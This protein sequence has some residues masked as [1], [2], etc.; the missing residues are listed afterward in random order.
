M[1]VLLF[2][3]ALVPH[4]TWYEIYER[5]EK[6]FLAKNYRAC[7]VDMNTAL[8][9]KPDP[10]RNQ[11]TRAVQKIDYKPF[12]YKAL[13]YQQLDNLPK[14]YE[15]AQHAFA[16]EVVQHAPLLQAK[17]AVILEHYRQWVSTFHHRYAKERALISQRAVILELLADGKLEEAQERL[18]QVLP[19]KDFDDLT[20]Q[21]Q[22]Q[23]S[24]NTQ[25]MQVRQ[26]LLNR[27]TSWIQKKE[28]TKAKTLFEAVGSSL[29]EENQLQI[30]LELVSLSKLEKA[31]PL[32][33][34]NRQATR[35]IEHFKTEI[36]LLESQKQNLTARVIEIEAQNQELQNRL[37]EEE[38]AQPSFE[39]SLTLLVRSVRALKVSLDARAILPFPIR[40]WQLDINGE[41]VFSGEMEPPEKHLFEWSQELVLKEFGHQSLQLRVRDNA[42]HHHQTHTTLFVKK[43][44]HHNP[45]LHQL[46]L[47]LIVLSV[48]LRLR[49]RK[50]QRKNARLLHFN[51]YIA[52]APIRK[53]EMFFGRDELL[54][55]I[56]SLVHKNSFMIHGPRRIGK[57]S[58]LLRL[59]KNLETLNS[60]QY[61][62]YPVLSDLQGIREADLFHH[63]MM[64]IL[65]QAEHWKIELP[66]LAFSDHSANYHTRYFSRDLRQLIETLRAA[67]DRHVILVLLIDEVDVL[68]E[69]HAKTNQKLRSIFMKDYAEHLTGVMAGIHLKKEWESSGSPWYNFFEEIPIEPLDELAARK[70]ITTPV[71]GVFRFHKNA[72]PLILKECKGHPYIIQKVC[73]SLIETKLKQNQ[74]HI[75]VKDVSTTLRQLENELRSQ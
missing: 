62:F 50:Q 23:K 56:Q 53:L 21:L 71:A 66:K 54:H 49:M 70:L 40:S 72:I 38:Q 2:F 28:Y 58:L 47:L 51:P 10:K 35:E 75:S 8:R 74:F 6:H 32:G 63:L 45:L 24:N 67:N 59:E 16:G 22:L 1:T 41:T 68:N 61:R 9:E 43:P 52:G 33:A 3:W 4:L 13:A 57:T 42:G 20:I 14:A 11:F 27:L 39:P 7:I 65:T 69:F 12:Y 31:L 48:V 18:A 60:E 73:V 37:S 46:A 44:L 29:K 5:G 26:N 17:L 64:D 25:L 34:S 55:R 19:N 15:N 36:Q 30:A